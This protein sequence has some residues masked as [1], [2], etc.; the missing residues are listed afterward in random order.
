MSSHEIT[1]PLPGTVYLRPSP[2]E[3][4]FVSVGGEVAAGDTVALIEVMKMFTPVTSE[5]AGTVKEI[6]V[7]PEGTV[8][9]G[10]VLITLDVADD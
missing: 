8:S 2:D 3:A 5:V 4:D 1:A 9:P 6:A 7:E 10:D